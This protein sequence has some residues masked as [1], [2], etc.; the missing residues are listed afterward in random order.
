MSSEAEVTT[1]PAPPLGEEPVKKAQ[2]VDPWTVESE[3]AIDY[4]RLM[5]D[6]GSQKI[7][8]ELIERIRTLTGKEPHRFLRRG[9]FFSH[10]DLGQMLDLYE[11]GT[12]FYLYVYCLPLSPSS[13]SS[14]C[15]CMCSSVCSTCAPHQLTHL[16]HI[17]HHCH[18]YHC[19]QV[20]G[21]RTVVRGAAPGPCDPF[22]LH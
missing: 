13:S 20:H 8:E 5:T 6:F 3:D 1:P 16:M 12:K 2:T 17:F 21:T 19:L 11:K 14:M 4:D 18:H 9:I 22:P 15:M 7:T 10:R